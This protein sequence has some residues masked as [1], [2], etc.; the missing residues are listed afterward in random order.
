MDRT[1]QGHIISWQ[2]STA[3]A[4][5]LFTYNEILTWHR[6]HAESRRAE[7]SSSN[8]RLILMMILCAMYIP[9]YF[10]LFLN[11]SVLEFGK[12]LFVGMCYWNKRGCVVWLFY[13]DTDFWTNVYVLNIF[14]FGITGI[15][16]V[17]KTVFLLYLFLLFNSLN[18]PLIVVFKYGA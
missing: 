10:R 15:F 13:Y 5:N 16:Y 11:V 14:S 17:S 12:P 2:R 1:S 3:V 4:N 8:R 9:R 6:C 18:Y 7:S